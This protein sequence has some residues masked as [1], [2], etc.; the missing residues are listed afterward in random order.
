MKKIIFYT[1]LIALFSTA[2]DTLTSDDEPIPEPVEEPQVLECNSTYAG[3]WTANSNCANDKEP[4]TITFNESENCDSTTIYNF[5]AEGKTVTIEF[6]SVSLVI[7]EQPIDDRYNIY[8][9]G[10]LNGD[11]LKFTFSKVDQNIGFS[12]ILCEL[13]AVKE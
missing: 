1:S 3:F 8:G 9:S 12:E 13:T 5:L 10:F 2:C 6:K 11:T 4:Y 7:P